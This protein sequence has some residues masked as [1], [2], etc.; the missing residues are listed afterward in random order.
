MNLSMR[1]SYGCLC[2]LHL[3][4]I[5]KASLGCVVEILLAN[6][7][8]FCQGSVLLN[9]EL[10]LQLVRFRCCELRLI[11][12]QLLQDFLAY[13]AI[14]LAHFASDKGISGAQQ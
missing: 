9:I 4:L 7:I 13:I 2:R 5:R 3:R 14:N 11:L 1:R 12:D 8:H 10:A 6:G